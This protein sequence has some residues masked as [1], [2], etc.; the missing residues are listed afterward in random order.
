VLVG[1]D[2]NMPVFFSLGVLDGPLPFKGSFECLRQ[3]A[4]S[5]VPLVHLLIAR[6]HIV[7]SQLDVVVN[8]HL[9]KLSVVAFLLNHDALLLDPRVDREKT[10]IVVIRELL[11]YRLDQN[12]GALEVEHRRKHLVDNKDNRALLNVVLG[13]LTVDFH[14]GLVT[15]FLHLLFARLVVREVRL[16][17]RSE[18]CPQRI[19]APG[20]RSPPLGLE[21]RGKLLQSLDAQQILTLSVEA[22]RRRVVLLSFV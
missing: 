11:E 19:Y 6:L 17:L 12:H 10:K 5:Q 2:V 13:Q 18:D 15:G 20:M 14:V 21:D 9:F 7:I 4:L 3:I 22:E 16:L 1:P 8:D